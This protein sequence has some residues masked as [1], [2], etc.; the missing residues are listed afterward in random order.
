MV[1]R[2]RPGQLAFIV[3]AALFTVVSVDLRAA[4]AAP[5][6]LAPYARVTAT[7]TRE[8]FVGLW[9]RETDDAAYTV[10]DGIER[11]SWKV[12]AEGGTLT[13]DLL[14][15][16]P[17]TPLGI[18]SITA[19]WARRPKGDTV[20]RVLAWCHG[21]VVREAL[22]PAGLDTF[23]FSAPTNGGCVELTLVKP[24]RAALRELSIFAADERTPR[25]IVNLIAAD[26]GT[27]EMALDW[28]APNGD[29]AF[30]EI[31]F[32]PPGVADP[33]A[34]HFVDRRLGAGPWIAPRPEESGWDVVAVPVAPNGQRGD[35]LRTRAPGRAEPTRAGFGA[36]EGFYG[37]PW[38]PIERRRM[39]LT[40]AR[41]GLGWYLY[42]PK[43]EPKHRDRWRETY[44]DVEMAAFQ[45]LLDLGRLVGVEVFYGIAPGR[46]MIVDDPGERATLIAK[47][48]PFV[49]AGY[50]GFMVMFDDIENDIDEPVDRKLGRKHA[51][52][53]EF[54]KA[55]LEMLAG[56]PVE[57]VVNPLAKRPEH[58]TD[59]PGGVEYAKAMGKVD[60]AIHLFWGAP[61][62]GHVLTGN[63]FETA[64]SFYGRP[65]IFWD[66]QFAND[67]GDG[68][69]GR[70]L[71]APLAFRAG[72]MLGDVSGFLGNLMF[73]GAAD[74][75]IAGTY[76]AYV[77]DPWNY[78]PF[79]ALDT[80]VAGL[81]DRPGDVQTL[82]H[83]VRYSFGSNDIGN[84]GTAFPLNLDMETAVPFFESAWATGDRDA[85]FS[86]GAELLRVAADMASIPDAMHHGGLD[87]ELVDDLWYPM[88]R[89]RSEGRA[90]LELMQHLGALISGTGDADALERADT[91]LRDAIFLR[92]QASPF[93]AHAFR[94]RVKCYD[95]PFT[96]FTKP[97][98]PGPSRGRASQAWVYETQPNAR[99]SIHGLPGVELSGRRATWTPTHPGVYQAIAVATSD[100][101]WAWRDLFITV[102]TQSFGDDDDGLAP[103]DD[104]DTD[105]PTDVTGD[106]GDENEDDESDGGCG[107]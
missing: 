90:L 102:E 93:F 23:V 45:E 8:K 65:P 32:V 4:L 50:R 16:F 35:A 98:L 25:P 26:R 107:C 9:P 75:I 83:A 7:G 42:A 19:D 88:L 14:P 27:G 94:D 1:A 64:R 63:D 104:D 87:A 55:E 59:W 3:V 39:I 73:L 99:L 77:A 84:P 72:D 81:A 67:G 103:G 105:G 95:A 58:M 18:T 91:L 62:D 53:A 13:A 76:G 97:A 29:P 96:H 48:A 69:T 71:M 41:A 21:P 89:P 61:T 2:V 68:F 11:T 74:R 6:D 10:R 60:Q 92:Y 56:E 106:A 86:R 82:A 40:L 37:T 43:D 47:L 46:D 12:H 78:D 33:G 30:V 85:V 36:I 101:G 31:F 80:N 100:E 17:R 28:Q 20:L 5:I 38:S 52:L 66:N 51:D 70:L 57:I 34:E 44:T 79:G 54:V 49:D 15:A 22:W 24:G